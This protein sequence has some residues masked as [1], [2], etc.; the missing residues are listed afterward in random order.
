M[1]GTV[2]E[3]CRGVHDGFLGGLG[4][5]DLGGEPAFAEDDDPVR[6]GQQLG[7]LARGHDD[8][9]ALR[10][11]PADQLVDLGL[12]ADVDAASRLVEQEH[13]GLD[14]EPAGE[15]ALLLV[16]AGEAGDRNVAA[17]RLDRQL[18]DGPLH[19]APLRSRVDQRAERQ[20]G[21]AA[22]RDIL[23]H[24][25][26]VEQ[27]QR[28]AVL[29]H[30]GDPGLD[31]LVG[32]GEI[33]P[34]ALEPDRARRLKRAG[35]EDRFE[36]L[37]PSGAQ[38]PRDAQHLA[39]VDAKSD[40]AQVGPAAPGRTGQRQALDLEDRP[41]RRSG[42][43]R[44]S[45]RRSHGRPSSGR[46]GPGEVSAR[47][48]V[49]TNWPSRSTVTRSA[50]VK[51]SFILWLMYSTVVPAFRKSAI[52]RKSRATSESDRAEVG[53]S[54]ITISA[55]NASALAI[56]TICWS[57]IRRSPTLARGEIAAPRRSNKLARPGLHRAVVEPAQPSAP[58]LLAAQEDVVGDRELGNQVE[59]LVDDPD[60]RVLGL[61]R[62][63]EPD[64]PAV[65]HDLAFVFGDRA[66]QDLHERALARP[67]LAADARGPRRRAAVNDTSRSAR[68][69]PK[70][71]EMCRISSRLVCGGV[72]VSE[73]I[74]RLVM[75]RSIDRRHGVMKRPGNLDEPG[76]AIQ[77][78]DERVTHARPERHTWD[79]SLMVLCRPRGSKGG[80]HVSPR[81]ATSRKQKQDLNL[82]T[83][84]W[85]F[86]I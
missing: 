14:Q 8:G 44:N 85:H 12:G 4:A 19:G 65:E 15:D 26:A 38:E 64:R 2:E 3:R 34:G 43:A 57:P 5:R 78:P 51:T 46:P 41:L 47:A 60:P 9:A 63:R 28:L 17:G 39:R 86:R 71:L 54:M 81:A 74:L 53:S 25:H 55:S 30:H 62:S 80:C 27:A 59:L 69:P 22:E 82:G 73:C 66:G 56:S 70:L 32:M 48:A 23:G 61:P 49:A 50:S 1:L 29:G 58:G 40:V 72:T 79:L 35:A 45:G 16:A 83:W 20:L 31:R 11:Q 77:G 52:T 10:G 36:Q 7:Q 68:T 24:G 67:V 76:G 33:A 37:G 6:D 75:S 18:L 84:I 42:A 13:L 21:E